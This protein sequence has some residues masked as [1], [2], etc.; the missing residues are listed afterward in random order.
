MSAA[1]DVEAFLARV[2]ARAGADPRADLRESLRADLQAKGH[3]GKL[4]QAPPHEYGALALPWPGLGDLLPDGGLPRGVVELAAPRALGG[5]TSVA[6]AAVRSGQAR[7]R[8]AWCAWIDPEGTL[9]A[10]GVVAAGVD[11]DRLLV[12]RAPRAQ[13]AR[14]A[15]K[16]VGAGAFEVV[17]VD[18]DAVPGAGV[19]GGAAVTGPGAKKRK[20]W[21]PEV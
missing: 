14:V 16:V 2:G 17:V 3:G 12:V 5:S 18:C 4:W 21:A 15:V 8:S 1:H 7:A 19:A 11:L 13:L 6:L 9:H 10:P 20:T